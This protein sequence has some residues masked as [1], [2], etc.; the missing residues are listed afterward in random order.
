MILFPADLPSPTISGY[1]YSPQDSVVR[2]AM[3]TGEARQRR[4]YTA[5]PKIAKVV[6]VLPQEQFREFE[7]W[8]D[9]E[10]ASGAAWFMLDIITGEDV[11]SRQVRFTKPYS[12]TYIGLNWTIKAEIEIRRTA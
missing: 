6:W 11:D 2:T 5:V 4:R 12:A 3:D 1:G 9:N 7:R 8:Y 10:A